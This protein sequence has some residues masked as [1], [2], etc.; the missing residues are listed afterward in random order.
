MEENDDVE[1]FLNHSSLFSFSGTVASIAPSATVGPAS[2]KSPWTEGAYL[3]S[4]VLFCI[5][6][7]AIVPFCL[8]HPAVC[9]Q[10]TTVVQCLPTTAAPSISSL[11]LR[12]SGTY[13]N[14][15][16]P[17]LNGSV[18]NWQADTYVTSGESFVQ[19][20]SSSFNNIATTDPGIFGSLR[21]F[22]AQGE[23]INTYSIPVSIF[24]HP[25]ACVLP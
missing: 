25:G 18:A 20:L 7:A 22:G 2:V 4:V 23:P 13:I 9:S 21:F 10:A 1:H 19:L 24:L 14:C 6:G 16:G 5:F 17:A 8:L 11:H 12:G 15:G 3:R